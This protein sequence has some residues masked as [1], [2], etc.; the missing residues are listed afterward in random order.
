MLHDHLDLRVGAGGG[1]VRE[2]PARELLPALLGDEGTDSGHHGEPDER[3]CQHPTPAGAYGVGDC[4]ESCEW[5]EHH[6][7][8]EHEDV[9]GEPEDHVKHVSSLDPAQGRTGKGDL[10]HLP[11]PGRADADQQGRIPRRHG[12]TSGPQH[13]AALSSAGRPRCQS[14][15]ST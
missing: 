10:S 14:A 1:L 3:P 15:R 6:I 9:D 4:D 11:A 5:P 8:M 7:G 12:A 13:A 2:E